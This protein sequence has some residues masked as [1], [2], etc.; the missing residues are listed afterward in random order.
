LQV[1]EPD[2]FSQHEKDLAA[3]DQAHQIAPGCFERNTSKGLLTNS[4]AKWK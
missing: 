2:I 4:A 1:F 3:F